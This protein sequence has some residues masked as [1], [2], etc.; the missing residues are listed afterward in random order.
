ME[1]I[2]TRSLHAVFVRAV[3]AAVILALGGCVTPENGGVKGLEQPTNTSSTNVANSALAPDVQ[4]AFVVA[5]A[6]INAVVRASKQEMDDACNNQIRAMQGECL[7]FRTIG[8]Q[9][10]EVKYADSSKTGQWSLN[11][12]LSVA[13][14]VDGLHTYTSSTD[15]AV[16]F[17][18]A[19][20]TLH[21]FSIQT[22]DTPRA[23]SS[24]VNIDYALGQQPVSL[25]YVVGAA[26][27]SGQF[28]LNGL[29]YQLQWT[30]KPEAE[31]CA[32]AMK[33]G[34]SAALLAGCFV[35]GQNIYLR[36]SG[37]TLSDNQGGT[38]FISGEELSAKVL[39]VLAGR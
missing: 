14:S 32:Q 30:V 8:F 19:S 38:S 25:N 4:G 36:F 1:H 15:V 22:R 29:L 27:G 16:H 37:W 13:H 12:F 5:L 28:N 20:P 31:R 34:D 35:A 26:T 24:T 7:A 10:R 33:N 11:G 2:S 3:S 6:S 23:G 18:Q 21:A 39:A 17:V 9:N